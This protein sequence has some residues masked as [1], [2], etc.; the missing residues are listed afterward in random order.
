MRAGEREGLKSE[1]QTALLPTPSE[2]TQ[3]ND[4][5]EKSIAQ[6]NSSNGHVPWVKLREN[7]SREISAF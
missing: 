7:D 5:G 4:N 6:A 2:Q 3:A 1:R